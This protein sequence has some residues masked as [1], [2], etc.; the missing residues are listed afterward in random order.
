MQ[1]NFKRRDQHSLRQ[2]IS[3]PWWELLRYSLPKS[4][5]YLKTISYTLAIYVLE[6]FISVLPDS[7]QEGSR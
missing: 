2:L 7:K 6:D 1:N 3:H 4:L 5:P